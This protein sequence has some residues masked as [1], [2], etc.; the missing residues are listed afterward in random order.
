M[1]GGGLTSFQRSSACPDTFHLM[2]KFNIMKNCRSFLIICIS[3]ISAFAGHAQNSIECIDNKDDYKLVWSDEFEKD[4]RPDTNNWHYENGFVR[5]RE[6]QYYQPENACCKDGKL[7][8]EARRERRQNPQHVS[9]NEDW[10]KNREYAEYTSSSLLTRGLHSWMYGRFEMC[11]RIDTRPGLWPAFWTLGI[12]GGWP[13]NGEIDIMEYYDDMI[14]ANIAWGGEK[15]RQPVWDTFKLPLDSLLKTDSSWSDEFHVWRM[16][17]DNESIRLYL[18]DKLMNTADLAVTFNRDEEGKNPFHQPHYI[19]IN[20][21]VGGT[22][23]GDPS[24]TEFPAYYK[25]DYIRVY[26]K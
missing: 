10:R 7:V 14:L 24:H 3:I 16:D 8:I 12:G 6:L 26:Q 19:I 25:I 13:H 20:L 2:T 4:G 23:G 22:S 18:D 9:G 1:P 11:A 21:A 5:N 17:W 15:R